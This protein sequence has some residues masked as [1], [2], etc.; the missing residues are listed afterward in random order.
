MIEIYQLRLGT[1]LRGSRAKEPA[2]HL[3]GDLGTVG[4]FLFKLHWLKHLVLLFQAGGKS[5]KGSL[6]PG[7]AYDDLRWAMVTPSP[8]SVLPPPSNRATWG[9][10]PNSWRTDSRKRPVPLP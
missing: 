4:S 9:F 1:G 7:H 3:V 2:M 8:P 10:C 6:F 5:S